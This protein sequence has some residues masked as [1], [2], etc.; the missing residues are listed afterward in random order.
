VTGLAKELALVSAWDL[1][2]ELELVS[3]LVTGLE[4]EMEKE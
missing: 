2:S 3:V 1:E 4:W